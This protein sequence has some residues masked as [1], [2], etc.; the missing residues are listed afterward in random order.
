MVTSYVL[1]VLDRIKEIGIEE[2][3]NTK[4]LADTDDKLPNNIILKNVAILR[5]VL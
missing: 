5:D 3:D 2:F 4:I 1:E